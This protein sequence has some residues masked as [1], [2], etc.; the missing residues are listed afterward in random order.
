V[1]AAAGPINH[2]ELVGFAEEL[3]GG[4]KA[5]SKS[6][7]KPKSEEPRPL[8]CGT[9]LLYQSNDTPLAHFA[10]GYE[11]VPWTHPDSIT[12]MVMQSIIG[13]YKRGEGLVPPKLSGNRLTNNIANNMDPNLIDSYAAFNTCYK[14][15]GLFGFYGQADAG[16]VEATI[17]E[18]IFGVTGLA[19]T[20]TEDEVERGKRQLKTLLFGSLDSTTAVAEDIGRQL[21]VYGRRIPIVELAARIDAVN[22]P[23]VRRVAQKYLCDTDI[24]LTALGP[25]EGLPSISKIQAATSLNKV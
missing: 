21:L 18:L 24:A 3:F 15:T 5:R 2:A 12:F 1:L 4:Y 25:L 23:E 16:G 14:D 20:V 9:E 19:H 10:V 7:S 22:V 17:N 6:A 8:F 13:N 11:G